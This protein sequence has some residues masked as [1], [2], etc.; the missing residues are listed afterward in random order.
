MDV[1]LF[2]RL[3]V[4]RVGLYIVLASLVFGAFYWSLQAFAWGPLGDDSVRAN[5]IVSPLV[6]AFCAAS[7]IG[8]GVVAIFAV[9][10]VECV[11]QGDIRSCAI[12]QE[13]RIVGGFVGCLVMLSIVAIVLGETFRPAFS[14]ESSESKMLILRDKAIKEAIEEFRKMH[15]RYPLTLSEAG[16]ENNA[17]S[18]RRDV[19]WVYWTEDNCSEFV[20]QFGENRGQ[21]SCQYSSRCD[22]WRVVDGNEL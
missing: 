19:Q 20:L 18:D 21:R 5:A 1:Y 17:A 12:V 10:P 6:V 15:G 7:Q 13:R 16:I 11:S 3:W 2:L 8:A 4:T 22:C 14:C 9:K